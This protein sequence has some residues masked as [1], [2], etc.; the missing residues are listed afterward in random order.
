MFEIDAN[1]S[2]QDTQ[3]QTV[4]SE[5]SPKVDTNKVIENQRQVEL[6]EALRWTVSMIAGT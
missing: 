5:K 6:S 4:V 1:P 2:S 3:K